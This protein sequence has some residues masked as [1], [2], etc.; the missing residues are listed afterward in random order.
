[1][2]TRAIAKDRI[3]DYQSFEKYTT[4]MITIT[5]DAALSGKPIDVQTLF[6]R[7]TLDNSGEFLFGT[8]DFNTLDLP[9]PVAGKCKLGP[10]GPVTEGT[11][12]TFGTALEDAQLQ[13]IKRVSVPEILW[14]AKEFFWDGSAQSR[15]IMDEYLFPLA[16]KAV[17]KKWTVDGN[18]EAKEESSFLDHVAAS[19]DGKLAVGPEF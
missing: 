8:S 17:E 7:F 13:I 4:K 3:H 1:M 11:F 6:S 16:K 15:K 5:K 2:L 12:G 18:G 9:L 10:K 14:T 19:T